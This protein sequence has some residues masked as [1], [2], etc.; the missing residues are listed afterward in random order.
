MNKDS[1]LVNAPILTA[2]EYANWAAGRLIAQDKKLIILERALRLIS[3]EGD[4]LSQELARSALAK[5]Q[6]EGIK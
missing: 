4:G 5:T 6:N 1:V 3:L 2:E